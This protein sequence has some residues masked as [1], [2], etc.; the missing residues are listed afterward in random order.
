[1]QKLLKISFITFALVLFTDL[2]LG[3]YLLKFTPKKIDATVPHNIF[4]HN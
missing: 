1:M 3:S 4:D 2:I